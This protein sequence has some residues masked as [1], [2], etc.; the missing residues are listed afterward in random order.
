MRALSLSADLSAQAKCDFP[1][2]LRSKGSFGRTVN[3]NEAPVEPMS[4]ETFLFE[5]VR[6]PGRDS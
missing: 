6:Q 2:P 3:D 4:W 1:P 5:G